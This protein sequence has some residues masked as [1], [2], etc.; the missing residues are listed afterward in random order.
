M[1]DIARDYLGVKLTQ[2]ITMEGGTAGGDRKA[3]EA[4]KSDGGNRIKLQ[5]T[6]ST[7]RLKKIQKGFQIVHMDMNNAETGKV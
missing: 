6:Q 7:Q 3:E 2:K 4:S 5:E 1:P